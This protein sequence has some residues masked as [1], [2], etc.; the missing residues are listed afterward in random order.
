MQIYASWRDCQRP[1]IDFPRNAPATA[2]CVLGMLYRKIEIYSWKIL[3][4]DIQMKLRHLSYYE[5]E[6]ISWNTWAI[7][8]AELRWEA[9]ES[10]LRTATARGLA[11][12]MDVTR[13][14]RLCFTFLAPVLFKSIFH[15]FLPIAQLFLFA[16]SLKLS[17]PSVLLRL[18]HGCMS[19][20][21]ICLLTRSDIIG[22]LV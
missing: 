17:Q 5:D 3:T 12:Q 16:N 20:L 4:F 2:F 13:V 8:G 15:S 7:C 11:R 9:S 10:T 6:K 1:S 14:L 22:R 18:L 19:N 21:K